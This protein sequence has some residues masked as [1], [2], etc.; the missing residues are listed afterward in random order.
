MIHPLP[1][2]PSYLRQASNARRWVIAV[3]EGAHT[4][5]HAVA[6][7]YRTVRALSAPIAVI[8]RAYCH[9]EAVRLVRE[10]LQAPTGDDLLDTTIARYHARYLLIKAAHDKAQ[11]DIAVAE[12]RALQARAE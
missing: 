9:A 6:R 2:Q 3:A 7:A 4:A 5:P 1:P 11:S 12:Y 10:D 8:L